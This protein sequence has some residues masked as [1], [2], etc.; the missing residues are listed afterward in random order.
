M[1]SGV[2]VAEFSAAKLCCGKCALRAL[3]NQARLVFRQGGE[4]VD[5]KPIGQRHIGCDKIYAT[6]HQ[7]RDHRSASGQP[8]K[9]CNYEFGVIDP[10]EPK[11]FRKFWSA[12]VPAALDLGQ[13]SEH[14]AS[15][16]SDIAPNG[17][18][19]RQQAEP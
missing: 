11:R 17:V 6:F 18:L 5:R 10:A 13:F 14:F 16:C 4:D 19:L 1:R 9:P 2:W 12:I 3:R 8:I 15:V 7:A